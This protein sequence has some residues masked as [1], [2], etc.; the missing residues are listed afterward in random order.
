MQRGNLATALRS[1]GDLEKVID[2]LGTLPR[3]LAIEASP[4]LTKLLR[5]Q[6]ADGTDPYGRKWARLASGRASHLTQTRKLRQ[7]TRAVPMLGGRMGIRLI[8]GTRYGSFH[9]TRTRNMPARRIF[10]QFGM[11]R[12]WRDVLDQSALKLARRATQRLK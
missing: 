7:K 4:K 3:K 10:P 9:Q 12:A 6:F 2:E 11:P 5:K 8:F 1:L